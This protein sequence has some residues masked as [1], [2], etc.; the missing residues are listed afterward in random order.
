[1][2]FLHVG[3]EKSIEE[4]RGKNPMID[5]GDRYLI[6][7]DRPATLK[8]SP[9]ASHQVSVLPKEYFHVGPKGLNDPVGPVT[10]ERA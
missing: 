1:M 2:S 9:L 10:K 6:L 4:E 8:W 5:L 7:R 3:E